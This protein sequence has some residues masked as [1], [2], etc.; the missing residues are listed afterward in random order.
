MLQTP[1]SATDAS[2]IPLLQ[3]CQT[4]GVPVH[5]L[6]QSQPLQWPKIMIFK[7]LLGDY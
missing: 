1:H 5:G 7:Q 4:T 6:R 2:T 3:D